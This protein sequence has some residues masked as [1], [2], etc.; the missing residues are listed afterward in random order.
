MDAGKGVYSQDRRLST[1]KEIASFLGRDERTVKRWETARGLPV[2]RIP[3]GIRS[4]VFAYESE[5]RA[6]LGSQDAQAPQ[7]RSRRS[8]WPSA[9]LGLAAG[10]ALGIVALVTGLWASYP[11][12]A[13]SSN[14]HHRASVEAQAFYRAGLFEWQSRTPAGLRRAVDDFTQAIVRD[15]QYAE[16]YAGLAQCYELLREYTTATPDYAFPRAMAAADRAVALDPSL[17]EA[18]LARAFA[19]FYWSHDAATARRE[20]ERAIALAPASAVAHH[21][22]ATFLLETAEFPRA[23]EEIDRAAA[24]D[25]ESI[26]IQADK[27]LILFYAGR[28]PESISLLQR[29]EQTQPVFASTHRYLARVY[30]FEHDEAGFLRELSLAARATEDSDLDAVVS[31][32]RQGLSA[33][34]RSGMLRAML[35]TEEPLV[36]DGKGRAY[37]LATMHAELGD[38]GDSLAWLQRSLMR[39]EAE[40]A[41]LAIEP[42]FRGLRGSA[43]FRRLEKM[44]GVAPRV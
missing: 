27:G 7:E 33:S 14:A 40:F 29:L 22:Y 18:H 28:L 9:G 37:T 25:S 16:A 4:P 2:H 8:G 41:G 6:W 24:L 12:P 38:T 5:L 19:V 34:G 43:E 10:V 17:A 20:F 13:P 36:R 21:W 31:A 15:P 1:W 42:S 23:I 35:R 26:A 44:A 39:G 32:G 11:R 30:L 3:N